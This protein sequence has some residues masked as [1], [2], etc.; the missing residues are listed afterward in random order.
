MLG[1]VPFPIVHAGGSGY[2]SAELHL[3]RAPG[4]PTLQEWGATLREAAK[5]PRAKT[6][7]EVDAELDA[8][9]GAKDLDPQDLDFDFM[10]AS[11]FVD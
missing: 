11:D 10:N 9:S 8:A 4:G 1:H 3:K 5:D 7:G 2:G 6:W